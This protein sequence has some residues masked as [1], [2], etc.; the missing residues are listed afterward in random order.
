MMMKKKMI[1]SVIMAGVLTAGSA[2]VTFKGIDNPFSITASA[3]TTSQIQQLQSDVQTIANHINYVSY[4]QRG[5]STN[6]YNVVCALQRTL[7]T[8]YGANLSVDGGFG[9]ASENAVKNVQR[10]AGI[11]VDG[12]AGAG[13]LR[14]IQTKAN[15]YINANT[16]ATVSFNSMNCPTTL[17][18]GNSYYLGGTITSSGAPISSFK[19]EILSGNTVVMS[20]TI[21]PNA[22]SVNIGYSA[23]DSCLTFGKLNAGSYTLRY[24]ATAGSTTKTY[25]QAFTVQSKKATISFNSMSA[26]SSISQGKSF[27]LSGTIKTTNQPIYSI[28][29]QIK[30][31]S[32]SVV[33]SKTVYPNSYSYA[34]GYSAIDT[35]MKFGSLSGG[36]YTL[37]Y[38][39]TATDGTTASKTY[40]F[41]VNG[42]APVIN[43]SSGSSANA[44]K[45][46][47]AAKADIGKTAAQMGFASNEAW[48][49]KTTGRWLANIGINLESTPIVNNVVE[50]LV[51]YGYS[52]T[53]YVF[54]DTKGVFTSG[55]LYNLYG[56]GKVQKIENRNDVTLL[57][58]DVICW[59]WQNSTNTNYDHIGI[60]VSY[61]PATKK[62]TTL[63]GNAGEGTTST[64]KVCYCER[65]FDSTVVA[66][67]R[68]K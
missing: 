48:C 39:V 60:V 56:S 1:L 43:V 58:G 35:A 9:P 28:T 3:A 57:P 63:E 6:R 32:N 53:A 17:T 40:S 52:S 62:I 33:I 67:V 59:K 18:Q 47:Q 51:S 55:N 26:P 37:T 45:L 64:R 25:T 13:T 4:I 42:A 44:S 22:Y 38:N 24:T 15:A 66:V 14:V 2:A 30:N 8:L 61:D 54:K 7:N 11:A 27:Y 68:L 16:S 20:K 49:A 46:V 29:A 34:I 31:S 5:K 41:T 12:I 19:G 36:N 50:R 21:Y 23:V 10:N 65:N